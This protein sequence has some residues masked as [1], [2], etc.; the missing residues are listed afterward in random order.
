MESSSSFSPLGWSRLWFTIVQH[1]VNPLQASLLFHHPCR[2]LWVI[3]SPVPG[4]EAA[5]GE[6]EAA[7]A[8]VSWYF[9]CICSQVPWTMWHLWVCVVACHRQGLEEQP[10]WQGRE[11][12]LSWI[13][14]P[15]CRVFGNV[16]F[17]QP[18]GAGVPMEQGMAGSI[19]PVLT[20][21]HS[22]VCAA[23]TQCSS[24]LLSKAKQSIPAACLPGKPFAW[25][26]PKQDQATFC[27]TMSRLLGVLWGRK[28]EY[29]Q[30]RFINGG[31]FSVWGVGTD[32][33]LPK[34]W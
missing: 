29:S 33:K 21:P 3:S 30:K 13:L 15:G 14:A 16:E 1:K 20:A 4:A 31:I 23:Q 28:P 24:L 34:Y 18:D 22:P 10:P 9:V 12:S 7:A 5:R 25:H 19:S 2:S 32:G 17:G 6:H 8:A 11:E 26:F 27:K